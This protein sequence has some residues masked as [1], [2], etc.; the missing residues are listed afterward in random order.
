M[1]PLDSHSAWS[2]EPSTATVEH[3]GDER[4]DLGA[5]ERLQRDQRRRIVLPQRDDRV[6]SCFP[7]AQ[8]HHDCGGAAAYEERD[9]RGRRLVE[10]VRVVDADER[11]PRVCR[12][13]QRARRCRAALR[14]VAALPRWR[15]MR[16]AIAPSGTAEAACVAATHS[17]RSSAVAAAREHLVREARLPDAG[18]AGEDDAALLDECRGREREL[19]VPT[20]ERPAAR[21][22][23]TRARNSRGPDHRLPSCVNG[24]VRRE[25]ECEQVRL[26]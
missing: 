17:V 9:Q 10:Q 2:V 24:S 20:D 25:A 4:V 15:G 12:A 3:R 14:L 18:G 5:R 6:G 7:A 1:P 22:Q 21:V 26:S 11:R 23:R 19:V 13:V 8:R 16:C